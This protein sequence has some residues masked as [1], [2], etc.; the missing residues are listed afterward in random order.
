[1][2]SM[3]YS[4]LPLVVGVVGAGQMGA[5]IAQLLA[6][7]G[8]E[9]MLC[10]R[11]QEVLERGIG[12]IKKSLDRFIAKGTMAADDTGDAIDNLKPQT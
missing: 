12:S 9:V 7:K 10:D 2:A 5:G 8:M 1:M 3:L 4:H 11:N 6:T